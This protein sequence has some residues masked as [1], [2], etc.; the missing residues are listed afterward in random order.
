[1]KNDKFTDTKTY[2]YLEENNQTSFIKI[3]LFITIRIK[4]L[5]IEDFHAKQMLDK[6]LQLF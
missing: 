1:M 2:I 6:M 3:Y 4:L 5:K